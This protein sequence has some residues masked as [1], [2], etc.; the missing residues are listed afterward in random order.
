MKLFIINFIFNKFNINDI[1]KDILLC[2]FEIIVV[3]L[4][5]GYKVFFGNIGRILLFLVGF[6]VFILF[7][8]KLIL[9]CIFI[10]LV[11]LE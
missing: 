10:F 7:F 11:Y 6:F 1:F 9:V 2:Y 8:R 4:K 3:L 5:S